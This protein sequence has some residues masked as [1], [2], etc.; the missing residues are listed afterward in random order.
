MLQNTF[1]H[2]PGIGLKS[3]R[4]LWNAG[5]RSWDDFCDET[6]CRKA[7]FSSKKSELL[8]HQL[9][10]CHNRLCACDPSFFARSLPTQHLWR[11]FPDFRECA[12]YIDIE[13]TGLGGPRDHITTAAIYDGSNI[14]YYV[15]GD[16]L[17]LFPEDLLKYKI[18][19]SY[20][21]SCFDLPFIR[22]QFGVALDQV[23]VDLRYLLSSLGYRGGLKG[24]E[25]KLG[26]DRAELDGV[27]GYFAVLL[28]DE[29]KKR[30]NSK[31][32]ETL[33]AYNITDTVN[34]ENLM[35]QA[36]NLKIH[37]TPFHEQKL[38]LPSPPSIPFQ[39]DAELVSR[40]RDLCFA[41]Y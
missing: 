11:L 19:I 6:I 26:L 36:Y 15:Y 3:E 18:L 5:I 28:W 1:L 29:Y 21:G 40:L 31:A 16:N 34:L 4:T 33:L 9:H 25:K 23:H 17:D 37:E 14:S 39:A 38:P 13:T 8:R 20:N 32:L 22:S 10:L 27:D 30:G 35:V 12:A 7:P 24:C 41:A 2:L